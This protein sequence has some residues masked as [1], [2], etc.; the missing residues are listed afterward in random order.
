MFK[1]GSWQVGSVVM[2]SAV[3]SMITGSNPAV[4][5]GPFFF[6]SFSKYFLSI[7]AGTIAIAYCVQLPE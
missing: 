2:L 1:N 7:S 3:D 6:L 4:S 5:Y